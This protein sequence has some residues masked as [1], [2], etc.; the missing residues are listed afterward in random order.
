MSFDVATLWYAC[1][2]DSLFPHRPR[3]RIYLGER[4]KFFRYAAVP[5]VSGE[6]LSIEEGGLLR[7]DRDKACLSQ[8]RH[9]ESPG[10]P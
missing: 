9:E 1:C 2:R 10:F 5:N 3:A 4:T 7:I 8:L 6:D